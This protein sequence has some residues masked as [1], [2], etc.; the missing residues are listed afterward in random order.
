MVQNA[1]TNLALTDAEHSSTAQHN[2]ESARDRGDSGRF[3]VNSYADRLMDDLFQDVEQL[4]DP[5]RSRPRP[6]PES[7]S[8]SGS[9]SANGLVRPHQFRPS[10]TSPNPPTS[11]NSAAPE[12]P[13]S[14]IESLAPE[15]ESLGSLQG[16]SS[17][18]ESPQSSS[19][20]IDTY[21]NLVPSYQLAP[22]DF[23]ADGLGELSTSA[24]YSHPVV[25]PKASFDRLLLGVGC[26]S[27][28]IS[29]ALWLLYQ[30]SH[31]QRP[32]AQTVPAPTEQVSPFADYA[33][34]TIDRL[35]QQPGAPTNAAQPAGGIGQPAAPTV[36]IPPQPATSPVFAPRVSTGLERI[37][38]PNYQFPTSAA[39][40]SVL[41]T[42]LPTAPKA[43]T[44]FPLK[45]P[46]G[47]PAIKPGQIATGN[48]PSSGVV[49]RL[50]GVLNQGDRSVALFEVNGITQRFEIGEGIGSSGWTL[51]AVSQSQ[52]VIRRNGEVRSIY[53]GQTF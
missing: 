9:L 45:R 53:V 20:S 28:V 52:A 6:T 22:H 21:S 32:A 10:T 26:I 25:K 40:P 34:K 46:S 19:Y 37:Y 18:G 15:D 12:H 44:Q 17:Q 42:P 39:A 35:S 27:V 14:D 30:E 1:R 43:A 5:E 51:V 2:G 8:A 7:P 11:A 48:A 41:I 23:Y 31:R 49:Q 13:P 29:M 33:Q 47:L 50:S 24:A 3:S 4:V 36:A 16:V 38:V